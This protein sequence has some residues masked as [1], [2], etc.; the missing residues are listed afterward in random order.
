MSCTLIFGSSQVAV[1]VLME[2][3]RLVCAMVLEMCACLGKLGAAHM[4][5]FTSVLVD[6]ILP[7]RGSLK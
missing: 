5:K 6:I 1:W 7:F 2:E 4:A 3:G